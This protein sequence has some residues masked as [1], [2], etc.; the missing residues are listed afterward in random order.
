[1][2][3][4]NKLTNSI[5]ENF[6]V[7]T[8][9][10]NIFTFF[11][12]AIIFFIENVCAQTQPPIL[13]SPS[14]SDSDKSYEQNISIRVITFQLVPEG[15]SN[16][17]SILFSTLEDLGKVGT[18]IIEELGNSN[19]VRT[20]DEEK[21]INLGTQEEI[22]YNLSNSSKFKAKILGVDP[23][24]QSISL[25]TN[26]E[27]VRNGSSLNVVHATG[28]VKVG[29]YLLY[30]NLE[31]DDSVYHLV[32][33]VDS[34]DKDN[35]QDKNQGQNNENQE[36]K[37][38]QKDENS[39]IDESKVKNKEGENEKESERSQKEDNKE[40]DDKNIIL[41]LQSLE[42]TDKREQ[43]EMLNQRERIELPEHWW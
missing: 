31:F 41:L 10:M 12:I 17:T 13:L 36:K 3:I 38:T 21:E 22:V 35:K 7:R 42:D 18:S 27:A 33:L 25:E 20:F 37:D 8:I 4:K 29:E 9:N 16:N 24:S 40:Q 6:E 39:S 2:K 28:N 23:N 32:L 26:L 11:L 19:L 30:K 14:T 1:M 34:K 5:F 15:N 43:K